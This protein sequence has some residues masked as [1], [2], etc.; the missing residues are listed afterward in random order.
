MRLLPLLALGLSSLMFTCNPD[1]GDCREQR[2][3]GVERVSAPDSGRVGVPVPVEIRY[4][5]DNGCARLDSL[6]VSGTGDRRNIQVKVSY[7][8]C[9]C[10]MVFG[11]GDTTYPF[12]ASSPGTYYIQV[13]D[14][15]L[16]ELIDTIHIR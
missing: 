14:R 8:G 7:I 6:Q 2:I 1:N 11:T 10:S 12:V 15:G 13:S 5:L 4:Q 16:N 3:G 9:I